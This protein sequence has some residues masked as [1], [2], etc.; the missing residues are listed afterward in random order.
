MTI[1]RNYLPV[2]EII[3]IT[4]AELFSRDHISAAFG[5]TLQ[6]ENIERVTITLEALA[7]VRPYNG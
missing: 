7:D 5:P 4:G 1:T 6:P 3:T 2:E